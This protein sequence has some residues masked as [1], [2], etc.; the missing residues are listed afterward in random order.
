MPPRVDPVPEITLYGDLGGQADP[1]GYF[2]FGD[3]S[4]LNNFLNQPSYDPFAGVDFG[5][6]APSQPQQPPPP[7]PV[8]TPPPPV[9]PVK[10]PSPPANDPIASPAPPPPPALQEIQIT[11][12]RITPRSS[13]P[14]MASAAAIAGNIFAELLLP[15]VYR[16]FDPLARYVPFLGLQPRITPTPRPGGGQAPARAPAPA[17]RQEPQPLDQVVVRGSPRAAPAPFATPLLS[18]NTLTNVMIA[19]APALRP[20]AQP[21]ARPAPRTRAMPRVSTAPAN[22]ALQA[23]RNA[24]NPRTSPAYNLGPRSPT[25][26]PL[27]PTPVPPT[28]SPRPAPGPSPSPYVPPFNNPLDMVSIAPRTVAQPAL[29]RCGC[30]KPKERKPREPRTTC[31]TGTY[32]QTAKGIRYSPKRTIPCQ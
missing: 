26:L 18:P 11:A 29:D 32:T 4:T 25:L 19:T 10:P 23:W 21:R 15:H 7:P 31:R 9:V 13:V 24:L 1:P 30:P 6:A 16:M 5:A 22:A 2:H 14:A 27:V 20:L 8:L 12:P 28:A 17:P 3:L